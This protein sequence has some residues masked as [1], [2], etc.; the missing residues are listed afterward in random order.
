MKKLT[1]ILLSVILLLSLA[2][3]GASTSAKQEAEPAEN[4]A[5]PVLMSAGATAADAAALRSDS[6]MGNDPDTP[7][8]PENRKWIIT[9]DMNVETDNLDV[10]Q[11]SLNETI[12]ALGGYIE[13]Q[14]VYNG[15]TY[16]N[17]R[18]R[19]ASLTVRI[20]AENVDQFTQTMGGIANVV[21]N[22][23]RR[24]DVTLQYVDTEGRINALK[25]E[26]ARLLE[27]LA[28]A[29]NMTDLLQIE[30]RLSEVRYELESYTSR[31]NT[32]DNKINYATV[33]I[34]VE[35]VQEY[36]PTEEPTLWARI[37]QGLSNSAKGLVESL[38]NLLVF[39]IVNIPYMIVYGGIV[40]LLI[41]A[42]RKLHKRK[43]GKPAHLQKTEGPQ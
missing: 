27:L 31:L 40:L 16:A 43:A 19:N 37:T 13:N 8:I 41:L 12:A 17:R 26:E 24:E 25:T 9:V 39:L 33:N 4:A 21:S 20:P 42:V 6:G 38:E 35:E 3:C 23:L 15:S 36:T 29:Q 18:Y 28:S 30:A 22:N 10:L 11:D 5:A 1:C 2:A 7:S 32:L 34:Y 14:S